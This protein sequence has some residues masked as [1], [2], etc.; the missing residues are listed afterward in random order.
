MDYNRY[1]STVNTEQ[2]DIKNNHEQC[3]SQTVILHFNQFSNKHLI[4]L[5]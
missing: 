1:S 3:D 4:L 2:R 5:L